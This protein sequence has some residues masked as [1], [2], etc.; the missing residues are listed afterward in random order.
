MNSATPYPSYLCTDTVPLCTVYQYLS[1]D[2]TLTSPA[3]YHVQSGPEICCGFLYDCFYF[4]NNCFCVGIWWIVKCSAWLYGPE[5]ST[6]CACDPRA[7]AQRYAPITWEPSECHAA[8]LL[9]F[10]F[11]YSGVLTDW[12]WCF[13]FLKVCCKAHGRELLN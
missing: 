4:Y 6:V 12:G 5:N 10:L 11:I 7:T 3:H 13:I 8:E 2:S 9:F 1:T